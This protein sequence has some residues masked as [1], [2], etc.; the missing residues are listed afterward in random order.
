MRAWLIEGQTGPQDL[1]LVERGKPTISGTEVLV[2]MTA[3]GVVPFDWAVINDENESTFPPANLPIIPGNQGAGIVEDPGSSAFKAG[4]RVMFG[5]FPYGF[6]R[7]GSWAEYITVEADHMT[8][9]P[10]SVPDGAAAQAAVAYPTAYQALLEAGMQ[11][12]K[13][14]LATGIGG[15]VGNAGYQLAKAM[16]AKAVFST[17]G[18]PAKAARAAQAGFDNVIDLSR[19]S[20]ADGVRSRND[21]AGV[22]IIIDSVGGQVIAEAIKSLGRYGKAIA[23]GFAAGRGSTI[24]L[25]DLILV[26]GSIQ[27]YGVYTCTPE[28]WRGAWAAFTQFADA[29]AVKPIFDRDFEFE[30]APEALRYMAQ[31]RPFGA[32]SLRL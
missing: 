18:S 20:I 29:G 27:G 8:R 22:D 3:P 21:G 26:R 14:V 13:T 12:G 9:I 16:G 1:R 23:L 10:A 4:D 31:A 6:M 28:E 19:E 32:V 24:T 11:A 25:A 17:A 5:A 7:P 15:S 30:E 2:R